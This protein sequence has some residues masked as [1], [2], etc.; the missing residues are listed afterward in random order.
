MTGRS[1]TATATAIPTSTA[2]GAGEPLTGTT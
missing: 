1:P 2:M